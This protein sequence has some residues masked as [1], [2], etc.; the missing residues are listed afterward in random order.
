MSCQCLGHGTLVKIVISHLV[1]G[2]GLDLGEF[3]LHVVGVHRANLVASR[4]AEYFDDLHELVDT[5]LAR[6]E[7]LSK[8][9]LGHDTASGPH[10]CDLSVNRSFARSL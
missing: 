5:R 4:C 1:E 8:H 10:I 9:E 2:V 3:V 6:E 7:R